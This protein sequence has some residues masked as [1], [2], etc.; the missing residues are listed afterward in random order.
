MW[1]GTFDSWVGSQD[2]IVLEPASGRADGPA[3]SA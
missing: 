3:R 1:S 2:V